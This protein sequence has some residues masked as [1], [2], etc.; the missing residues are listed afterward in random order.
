MPSMAFAT[1]RRRSWRKNRISARTG[2]PMRQEAGGRARVLC[3]LGSGKRASQAAFSAELHR[4]S[5]HGRRGRQA[6]CFW[7]E[8]KRGAPNRSLGTERANVGSD[9]FIDKTRSCPY[10]YSDVRNLFRARIPR[11]GEERPQLFEMLRPATLGRALEGGQFS[12]SKHRHATGIGEPPRCV[13]EWRKPA[14]NAAYSGDPP[15]KQDEPRSRQPD[16]RAA[17]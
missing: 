2:G 5:G 12:Y 4:R 3:G 11:P 9:I 8:S 1:A 6:S 10:T 14:E 17:Q 13:G 15:S 16:H 7:V